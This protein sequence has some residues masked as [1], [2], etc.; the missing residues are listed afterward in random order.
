MRA[1]VVLLVA[2]LVAT[3]IALAVP[4]AMPSLLAALV[5]ASWFV[6]LRRSLPR[7]IGAS[8]PVV[9]AMHDG[10]PVVLEFSDLV[11]HT[12]V[13]GQSGTGKSELL[14]ALL[15]QHL[16]I[17]GGAL[18]VDAKL[19][20]RT[21][22]HLR[23]LCRV[24][25]RDD[26]LR[27]LN[28]DDPA[29][30]HTWNPM[31]RGDADEIVSRFILTY[32]AVTGDADHWVN[33]QLSALQA[34]VGAL[35]ALGNPFTLRDLYILAIDPHLIESDLIGKI[36]KMPRRSNALNEAY[37][38]LLI[39]LDSYRD[40][41]VGKAG[42]AGPTVNLRRVKTDLGGAVGRLGPFSRDKIHAVVGAHHP[43][44]DFFEAIRTGQ[45]L[46]VMLPSMAKSKLGQNIA[47]MVLSDL[48]SALA[49]VQKL[50]VKPPPFLAILDEF[51]SYVL[52]G[53]DRVF[54]Q[55]RSA[56]LCLVPA[57]QTVANFRAVGED[58]AQMMTGNT[59]TRV[60]LRLGDADSAEWAAD[61][62]GH[63]ERWFASV[64]EGATRGRTLGGRDPLGATSRGKSQSEGWTKR[65]DHLVRPRAFQ[66]QAVGEAVV[67]R[68]PTHV[69]G[70]RLPMVKI[71]PE[72]LA[73]VPKVEALRRPRRVQPAKTRSGLPVDYFDATVAAR[74]YHQAPPERA[75]T[76]SRERD[77]ATETER[78]AA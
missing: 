42:N 40:H 8:P 3:V 56:G 4:A 73:R 76:P 38:H 19:D 74:G 69:V 11:R 23:N 72:A 13:L 7:P 33:M 68:G 63:E 67:Q 52:E 65:L 9:L 53:M 61:L 16:R 46:Y 21:L 47:K 78:G 10:R 45:L 57:V 35:V 32:G 34:I 66:V 30:S 60:Y 50:E 41:G 31:L 28:V 15:A 43:E 22:D 5:L 70:V 20:Y 36:A 27:V 1:A 24:L 51:G 18:F 17:G 48:R 37:E 75:P 71:R 44:I 77:P 64:S 54:E 55:A 58:V 12:L 14:F 49:A 62:V 39:W 26:D 29:Q 59:W 2:P 6:P 25:G